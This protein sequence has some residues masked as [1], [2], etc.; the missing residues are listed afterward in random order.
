[1]LAESSATGV[2]PYLAYNDRLWMKRD[3]TLATLDLLPS[4]FPPGS[5]GHRYQAAAKKNH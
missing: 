3:L 2:N 1:M 5:V 4:H